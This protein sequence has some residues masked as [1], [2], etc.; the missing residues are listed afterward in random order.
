MKILHSHQLYCSNHHRLTGTSPTAICFRPRRSPT[1][2]VL[3]F[4]I[5]PRCLIKSCPF[6]HPV[7][8]QSSPIPLREPNFQSPPRQKISA[9]PS[10][11]DLPH[12]KFHPRRKIHAREQNLPIECRYVCRAYILFKETSFFFSLFSRR[13][14]PFW[15]RY[16]RSSNLGSHK[17]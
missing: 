1:P 8:K 11:F 13:F 17:V 12:P 4:S 15:R 14:E 9:L 5:Y 10:Q 16:C 6:P 2:I 3:A 7:S